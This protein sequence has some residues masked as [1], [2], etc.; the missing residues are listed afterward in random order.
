MSSNV[1]PGR[2]NG[3]QAEDSLEMEFSIALAGIIE[4]SEENPA[5]LRNTIYELARIMLQREALQRS[6][7]MDNSEIERRNLALESAIERVEALASQ[8]EKSRAA[9]SPDRRIESSAAGPNGF[10]ALPRDPILS[11]GLDPITTTGAA[12]TPAP[13]TLAKRPPP[14]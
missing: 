10:A 8:L 2:T 3:G 7:A 6:P 12:H 4:S 1:W 13:S 9:R 5:Q 14:M 11:V